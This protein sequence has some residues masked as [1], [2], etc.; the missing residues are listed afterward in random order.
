MTVLFVMHCFY[1]FHPYFLPWSCMHDFT[2]VFMRR[3]LVD[4]RNGP[5][6]LIYLTH[7]GKTSQTQSFMVSHAYELS[8]KILWPRFPGLELYEGATSI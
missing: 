1:I 6:L 7:Q 4:T 8:L 3:P 2:S 5:Q